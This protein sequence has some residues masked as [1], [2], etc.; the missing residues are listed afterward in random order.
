[1]TQSPAKLS[2]DATEDREALLELGRVCVEIVH[3][4]RNELNALKLYATF[5]LKRSQKNNWLPDE[6]ET[7][8]KVFVGLERSTSALATLESYSRRIEPAKQRGA[9]LGQMVL[10]ISQDS[11]LEK[12]VT[13]DLRKSLCIQTESGSFSGDH[14]P[15]LLRE[16]LAAITFGALKLR[17]QGP[18]P[19]P[20][21]ILLHRERSESG[22]EG[23]IDWKGDGFSTDALLTSVGI[24]RVMV[25]FAARILAAHSGTIESCAGAIRARL[26]LSQ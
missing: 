26:P 15:R 3:D 1:M 16:A 11:S 7:L 13:E 5:L 18:H 10:A 21:Q 19:G 2:P 20:I 8:A 17:S 14:D 6:Q 23:V 4:A 25:A 22:T 12:M 24:P 9:D